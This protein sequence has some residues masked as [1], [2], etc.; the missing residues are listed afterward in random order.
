MEI[1][2]KKDSPI[3]TQ[4]HPNE[5]A[6]YDIVATSEPI[7]L[8]EYIEMPLD[9]GVGVRFYRRI[10]A[11]QYKTNLFYTP[12]SENVYP[13][14]SSELE[15]EVMKGGVRLAEKHFHTHIFPRSSI[16]KTNLTLANG[17]ATIDAGYTGELVV[18]FKYVSQP[19]DLMIFPQDGINRFFTKIN[20]DK[21]YQQGN[22]IAQ[23]VV[24]PTTFAKFT[25]VETLPE[26]VR[27]EKGFGSSGV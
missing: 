7:I 6:G 5:D 24:F 12:I 9:F 3:P 17:V 21:I 20:K 4:A 8:G 22:K 18:N 23:M 27:G 13:V 25:P 11:I 19:E 2:I 1:L 15:V 14:L 16:W 10:D 26:K